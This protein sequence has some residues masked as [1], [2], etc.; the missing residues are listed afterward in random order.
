MSY[1]RTISELAAQHGGHITRAQ[2][3]E[4]GL[5]DPMI[6][7]RVSGGL[8]TRVKSGVY[9]T[10]TPPDDEALL[11][12]AVLSLRAAVVS[13]RSAAGLHGITGLQGGRPVVTVPA[14]TTHEFPGVDVRRTADLTRLHWQVKAGFPVTTLVR[15]VFDLASCTGESAY[16]ELVDGLLTSQRLKLRQLARLLG[17]IGGKGKPGTTLVRAFVEERSANGDEDATPLERLGLKV[18]RSGGLAPDAVQYDPGF[19]PIVRFDA[20]FL[21]PK[22]AIEWDSR[23][24]HTSVE[25]FQSD[26]HRDR[27]AATHGW[28][29]LRFTWDDVKAR[30]DQVISQIRSVTER[31]SA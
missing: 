26:R 30:P 23:R 25:R 18:L 17:E 15:T 2:L 20:A 29:T 8:L 1:E 24:W 13:H 9:R 31:R 5:S 3:V 4:L 6:S 22:V 28:V 10:F 21:A 19:V 7:R 14:S 16:I 27:V 12:G 11:R